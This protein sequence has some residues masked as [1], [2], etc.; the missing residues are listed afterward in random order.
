MN[1]DPINYHVINSQPIIRKCILLVIYHI[2]EFI[3]D[4]YCLM[5]YVAVSTFTDGLQSVNKR[6]EEEKMNKSSAQYMSLRIVRRV[7]FKHKYKKDK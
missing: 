7:K 1:I 5:P 3:A 4:R 2:S 6:R